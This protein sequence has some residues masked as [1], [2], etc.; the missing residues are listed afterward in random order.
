MDKT[1]FSCLHTHTVFCDG[2]D[3]VETVCRAAFEKGLVAVGFSSH[4]PVDTTGL[5]TGWHMKSARL[6]EYIDEVHAARRRWEGKIAVYLGLELDY[7]RGLRSP[8]DR[9][10][11]DLHLDYAIGSVHYLVPPRGAPFTVDGPAEELEQ[12]IAEG[13]GGDGEAMMNAYWD[14]VGEM[15]ALGGFDIIGHFDLVKKNN[16][17]GLW[18]SMGSHYMR[19]VEGIAASLGSS[20]LVV[21]VNTGGLTRD[22]IT[23]TYPS[24]PILRLLRRYTVPVM[25]NADAHRAADLD[26][27]YEKARQTMLEAGY[28]SHVVF[29]GRAD[30]KPIWREYPL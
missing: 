4:A 28:Q 19:R 5:V 9:D 21:E 20:G 12:G 10:I 13:Y 8:A 14:A 16:G 17:A 7:I 18:F 2:K 24:L 27:H 29:E 23:E 11:Q 1:H 26:S 3:D 15:A 25:I 22:Y 30:G 6:A